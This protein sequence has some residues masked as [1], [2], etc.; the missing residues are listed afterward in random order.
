LHRIIL[1]EFKAYIKKYSSKIEEYRLI[2]LIL[3]I[4][5]KDDIEELKTEK[6]EIILYWRIFEQEF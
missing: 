6:G 2:G 5:I 4:D 1:I 3:S